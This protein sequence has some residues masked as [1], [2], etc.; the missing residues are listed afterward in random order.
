MEGSWVTKLSTDRNGSSCSTPQNPWYANGV[1]SRFER[2]PKALQG[3][4]MI[5]YDDPEC[6]TP[7]PTALA[8]FRK[9]HPDYR[10]AD[11]EW[12]LPSGLDPGL[13]RD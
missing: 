13:R 11:I 3:R 4:I 12:V 1:Q 10:A 8:I 6:T 5:E 7:V 2:E 9:P